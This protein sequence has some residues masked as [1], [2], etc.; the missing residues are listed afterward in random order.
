MTRLR[1]LNAETRRVAEERREE[2]PSANPHVV[3]DDYGVRVTDRHSA[4]RADY[5]GSRLTAAL[6]GSTDSALN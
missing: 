6:C 1:R 4:R 2:E 3:A 5:F